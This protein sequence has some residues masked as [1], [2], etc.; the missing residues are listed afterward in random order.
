MNRILTIAY[1]GNGKSTNRYHIPFVLNRADKI[2][3]KT[4][5]RRNPS[6]DHWAKIDGV[7]YTTD[8][9]E[10]LCDPEIDLVCVCASSQHYELAKQVLQHGKHCLV[11]KPFTNTLAQAEELYRI[12]QEQ[13]VLVEPYQNRRYDSELL[14]LQKVMASG[15]LGELYEVELHV[16]LFRPEA[17]EAVKHFDPYESMLYGLACHKLDQVLS[18][19][20][21]PDNV[22]WDVK[23]LLGEGRMSDYFDLDLFYGTLKVS[24]KASFFRI[25]PR[26]AV[27]AYGRNGLFVKAK[28]DRQEEHLKLFYLPGQPGFGEDRPEDYGVLTWRENGIIRE[29]TVPTVQGD[30]ARVYDALYDAIINHAP[31]KVTKEQ[32]LTQ[33]RILE[34]CIQGLH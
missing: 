9:N 20:G 17:S 1:I 33:I 21:T 10:V 18:I 13:G 25:K 2:R 28:T 5:Y 24:V 14:T 11:E 19:F 8:L 16:D 27:T 22:K 29:E 26:S 30:Y 3:I 4:V 7:H 32:S 12:A 6:H 23:Q 31:Q 34:M 15:K